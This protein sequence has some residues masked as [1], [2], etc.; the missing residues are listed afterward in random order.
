M[1]QLENSMTLYDKYGGEGTIKTLVEAFYD[2]ILKD[3]SL[4]PVF[5]KVDMGPLK[6]H[7][8]LF[9]SQA[10]GGPKQYEG[11]D[12]AEAHRGL[13]ITNGQFDRVAAHLGDAMAELGVSEE[14]IATI[15]TLVDSLRG[16]VVSAENLDSGLPQPEALTL[17]P[18]GEAP[19]F[20]P[21]GTDEAENLYEK[22]GGEHTIKTVVEKFYERVLGDATLA[23][24]FAGVEMGNL[25]RHQALFFSQA[26]GGPK[27]YDGKSMYQAHL[28]LDIT[29]EQFDAVAGHLVATLQELNVE[30]ADIDTV[31]G[32]VAP[33]KDDIVLTLFQR[34]LR[35]A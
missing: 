10:L 17:E 13:A 4:A 5:E 20:S 7:Q 3:P 24:L 31:I 11:R 27:Q 22:L 12:L 16:Q 2:R 18:P 9:I 8:A 30:Q 33:L 32:A 28:G 14:D 34:W 23:P 21:A 26:L 19:D 35:A 29:G 6:R 15:V 25:K 1:S